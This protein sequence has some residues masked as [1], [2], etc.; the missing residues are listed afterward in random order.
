MRAF[1]L[2]SILMAPI[3]ALGFCA[4]AQASDLSYF[5]TIANTDVAT[6]G[7]GQLR[8]VGT[9]SLNVAGLSG[10]ITSAYLY[11][12]GP[13]NTNEALAN[14]AVSFGGQA[15]MGANIGVSQDNN[16]GF[17]NS[18]AYRADVS[19]VITGDGAYALR[20]FISGGHG[21]FANVNGASLIVFFQDGNAANNHDVVLFDGNDSNAPNDYD[22]DG[23]NAE[24]AGIQ[25]TS[26][27]AEMTLTISDG[28]ETFS[29]GSLTANGTIIDSG[30]FVDG[31]TVQT[32]DGAFPGG[33]LWDNKTYDVSS[34]LTPG[35]NTITI[36]TVPREDA[37]SLIVAQFILPV[38]A[39]PVQP[40]AVP[41]PATWAMFI[42]GF[43]LVGAAMR[44]RQRVAV[45]FA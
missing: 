45:R 2:R 3:A 44:R 19:S 4:A 11:W 14:A 28:Q 30:H 25:F 12:H 36:N 5:T 1:Y 9:G 10:T 26:G 38:G 27:T 32:G 39:A 33:T 6:F 13:T 20:D 23:W 34:F 42:G 40:S 43:G 17:V 35:P 8:D 37:L 16:W 21:S 15:I 7:I 41:E 18:Q 24:L 31:L 22:A 29:D